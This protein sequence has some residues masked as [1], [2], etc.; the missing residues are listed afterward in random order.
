MWHGVP[1]ILGHNDSV[2]STPA[3]RHLCSADLGTKLRRGKRE[4]TGEA[5]K[6][7]KKIKKLRILLLSVTFQV[8][9]ATVPSAVT[10]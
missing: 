3:I 1:K 10:Q 4:Q 2:T 6:A 8:A 9:L 5:G 7:S